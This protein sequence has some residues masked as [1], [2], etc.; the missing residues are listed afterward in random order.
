MYINAPQISNL[1]YKTFKININ[2]C[3]LYQIN[4]YSLNNKNN[5]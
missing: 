4:Y 5:S 2:Y 3:M 1:Q